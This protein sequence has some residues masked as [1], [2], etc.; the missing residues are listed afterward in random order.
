MLFG[1]RLVLL[2]SEK[3]LTQAT[4]AYDMGISRATYSHYE[5][6]RSQPDIQFIKKLADYFNVSIDFL[7]GFSDQRSIYNVGDTGSC[8][9]YFTV[10]PSPA[11]GTTELGNP[12]YS[13]SFFDGSASSK[14][15]E[16]QEYFYLQATEDNMIPIIQIGDIVLFNKDNPVRNGDIAAVAFKETNC[17]KLFK[18]YKTG[19]YLLLL[20]TNP[21]YEPLTIK[22]D[23]VDI[24][25]TALFRLGPIA[26]SS[27]T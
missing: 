4:I 26:K 24:I 17:I 18:V 9:N 1:E 11:L 22:S 19:I 21:E 27:Y 5:T 25:G 8:L 16:N 10:F 20:S 2:R 3:N 6:G 7:L 13:H 14:L 23:R 15:P 12:I